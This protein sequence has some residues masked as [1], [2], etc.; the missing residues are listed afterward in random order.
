MV[1]AV[2]IID[3]SGTD[4]SVLNVFKGR[5]RTASHHQRPAIQVLF[6]DQILVCQGIIFICDQIDTAFKQVVDLNARDM[7][8]LLPQSKNDIRVIA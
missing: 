7:F 2:K 1:R 5:R 3:F 4:Q 8:C 6:A